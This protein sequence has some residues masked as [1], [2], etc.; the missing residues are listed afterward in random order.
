[1]WKRWLIIYKCGQQ[2]NYMIVIVRGTATEVEGIAASYQA[3]H[4][5]IQNI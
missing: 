3:P 5:N 4:L 1:M 2:A